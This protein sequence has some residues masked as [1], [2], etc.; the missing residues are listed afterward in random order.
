[1]PSPFPGMDPY[2]ERPNIWPD[3]HSDLAA[4]IRAE[5]NR[6]VQPGYVARI[7]PHVIYELVELS[8]RRQI[9]PDVAIYRS[10]RPMPRAGVAVAPI[11]PAPVIS[12]VPMEEM[13]ETFS[14]E[15]VTADENVLVT[16]IEILS[17]V[18]KTPGHD[19]YKGYLRK[20]RDLLYSEVHLL[21]IDL[22][23]AGT[24]PQL[25]QPVPDAPYYV[26]LSREERRPTV[27]VWPIQLHESLPVLPVPLLAPD[28]DVPLDL[29]MIVREVYDRGAYGALINYQEAPLPPLTKAEKE[30]LTQ[31]L[32]VAGLS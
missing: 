1:M 21:E 2:I 11:A 6:R 8:Q 14:V 16:A 10:Q 32:Q 17:P 26:V 5:L 20:R 18:N 25:T 22:L 24:R 23:R 3:F 12:R 28:A 9:Q 31:H 4:Q 29:G 19:A 15:I 27:E 13:V 7:V 30:W